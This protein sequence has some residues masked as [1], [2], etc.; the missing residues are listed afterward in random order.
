MSLE[1][2][3]F[4]LDLLK[5]TVSIYYGG[6]ILPIIVFFF[7]DL[8]FNIDLINSSIALS[9]FYISIPIGS[10]WGL[11][12]LSEKRWKVLYS[13]IFNTLMISILIYFFH[14]REYEL[15]FCTIILLT[16]LF[17][18]FKYIFRS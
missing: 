6:L 1:P 13:N 9:L 10:I 2:L 5:K 14:A 7:I 17:I 15:F 4:S 16:T 18:F 8:L 3:K 11:K 12:Y